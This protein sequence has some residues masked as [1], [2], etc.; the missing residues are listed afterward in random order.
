MYATKFLSRL[1]EKSSSAENLNDNSQPRIFL[2]VPDEFSSNLK[3]KSLSDY[4]ISSSPTNSR[5]NSRFNINFQNTSSCN[6]SFES[7]NNENNKIDIDNNLYYCPFD[8]DCIERIIPMN[9]IK[10]FQEEHDGP[11]IQY[12]KSKNTF[13]L[14]DKHFN[15]YCFIFEEKTFFLRIHKI[16]EEM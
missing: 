3:T 4:D 9:V 2:S 6:G 11:L 5:F 10:H 15:T 14:L 16:E 8:Q 7:L 1:A 12:F 13:K